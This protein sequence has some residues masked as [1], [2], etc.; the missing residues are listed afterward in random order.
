[1]MV[2]TFKVTDGAFT[3][4]DGEID[5][6]GV[7]D[8]FDKDELMQRLEVRFLTFV[9]TDFWRPF[10]GFD[11]KGIKE[12]GSDYKGVG[13]TEQE[14]LEHVVVET[15]LQDPEVAD[16]LSFSAVEGDDPREWNATVTFSTIYDK[17]DDITFKTSLVV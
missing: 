3:F 13:V 7:K 16:V 8:G 15:I 2:W 17:T 9:M 10:E 5:M 11:M 1:M 4:T 12:Q 14:L 6:I